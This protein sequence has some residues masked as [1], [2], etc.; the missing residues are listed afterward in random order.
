MLDAVV[1][2]GNSRI[3]LCRCDSKGLI[4]PVRGLHPTDFLPLLSIDE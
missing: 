2:F 3:K 4:L 1:D